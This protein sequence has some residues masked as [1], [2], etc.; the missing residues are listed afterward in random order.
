MSMVFVVSIICVNTV[1]NK[2]VQNTLI[3]R[4]DV[5]VLMVCVNT[6][7]E[8]NVVWLDNV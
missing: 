4:L 1:Q 8:E 3:V 7:V 5:V 2:N 6:V